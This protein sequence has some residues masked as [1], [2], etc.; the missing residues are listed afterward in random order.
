MLGLDVEF[1]EQS[2]LDLDVE[3]P[4]D[5]V[6]FCGVLYHLEDYATGLDRLRS[7]VTPATG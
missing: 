5:L 6:L 7:F 2:L 1:R 3:R 4:Y